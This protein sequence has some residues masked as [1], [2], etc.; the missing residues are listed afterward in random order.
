M[1]RGGDGG[2]H[3]EDGGA[4]LHRQRSELLRALRGG[5]HHRDAPC[6]P[7][8]LDAP[9]DEFRLRRSVVDALDD[10]RR[11]FRAGGGDLL[12]RDG[13]VFVANLHA[14]QVEHRQP[15]QLRE[16]GGEGRID[17][18]VHRRGDDRQIVRV[19]TERERGLH[20]LRVGGERAG[21]DRHVVEAPGVFQRLAARPRGGRDLHG[22]LAG[23]PR[24]H[25]AGHHV[26][27]PPVSA[28]RLPDLCPDTAPTRIVMRI[29]DTHPDTLRL[30][31]RR[32]LAAGGVFDAHVPPVLGAC[33][34]PLACHGCPATVQ[35]RSGFE[36]EYR[37]HRG[38]SRKVHRPDQMRVLARSTAARGRPSGPCYDPARCP[39]RCS[40]ASPG[41]MPTAR[42][43]SGRWRAP[44]CPRTS[45]RA[46]TACGAIAC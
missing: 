38:R 13:G 9:A 15:A 8:L 35:P 39:K 26:H 24:A 23:R 43:T 29:L 17:H 31:T 46:T 12:Q 30:H 32:P 20:Q 14:L 16:R 33:T 28:T 18:G 7:D 11:F 40:S 1:A 3:D 22:G 25:F 34:Q 45:S 19:L 6:P 27:L 36:R 41:R 37:C 44:T 4:G 5:A 10:G 42:S 2:L 21:D